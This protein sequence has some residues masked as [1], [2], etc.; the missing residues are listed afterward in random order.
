MPMSASLEP[1]NLQQMRVRLSVRY[2]NFL[3]QDDK[4]LQTWADATSR[5]P[6]WDWANE[7]RAF[8]LAQRGRAQE[9]ADT[10]QGLVQ[11]SPQRASAWFNLG[12]LLQQQGEKIRLDGLRAD[13]A[14]EQATI[15]DDE[16]DRAWYGLGL[17]R[18]TQGRLDEAVV[19]FKHCTRLQPMSPYA[20][21]QLAR[22]HQ[23]RGEMQSADQILAHLK[24]FDPKISN[25]LQRE[26]AS[27]AAGQ[28]A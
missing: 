18:V 10:L 16:N 20:W 28:P 27:P 1:G 21:Y 17:E 3:G 24:T 15:L 14:L 4:T 23:S 11:R 8:A 9:A 26:L 25:Q 19:C 22:V 7:N 13:A 2:W 6:Y 12:F 5:W